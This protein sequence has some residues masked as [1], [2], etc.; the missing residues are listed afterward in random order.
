[1]PI[2]CSGTVWSAFR[3]S[4]RPDSRP[5]RPFA[6]GVLGGHRVDAAFAVGNRGAVAER[7][8]ALGTG[9]RAYPRPV[10]HR[11]AFRERQ[12]E[13]C[14]RRRR[15]DAGAPDDRRRLDSPP[16]L[17]LQSA[18]VGERDAVAQQEPRC[19][20]AP[21]LC[22]SRSPI[23]GRQALRAASGRPRPA[24]SSPRRL[25]MFG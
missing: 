6:N 1:M 20:D 12:A 17:Q 24:R 19:R 23:F 5:E 10:V 15:R 7:P 21:E 3:A 22:A 18:V 11:P 2:A 13:L 4:R 8:D 25:P 14:D 16:A 9:R